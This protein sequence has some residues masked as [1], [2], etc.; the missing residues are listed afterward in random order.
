[1][2]N[3]ILGIFAAIGTGL[4]AIFYV[5]M[6]Q[7]KEERKAEEK[8][9]E[10][11]NENLSAIMAGEKAEKELRKENEELKEKAHSDNNLDAFNACN[12]LLQK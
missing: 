6:K 5:L 12:D 9:N 10:K 1:M 11:F 7:A 4:S 3:K 8:E 2:L